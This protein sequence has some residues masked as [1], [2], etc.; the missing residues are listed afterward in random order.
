MRIAFGVLF[1][2]VLPLAAQEQDGPRLGFEGQTLEAD[3]SV[4]FGAPSGVLV[5]E[6]TAGGPAEAAGLKRDDVVVEIDGAP[7]HGVEELVNKAQALGIGGELKVAVLRGKERLP[8][9]WKLQA[10]SEFAKMVGV[11][12]PS[13]RADGWVGGEA[14]VMAKLAGSVVAIVIWQSV[15][16]KAAD[17]E[18]M[19][20]S[21]H[22]AY[23]AKGLV[24][25]PVHVIIARG[26]GQTQPAEE[27]VKYVEGKKFPMPVGHGSGER[28]YLGGQQI[29]GPLVVADY[30]LQVVPSVI[31]VDK[32][33]VVAARWEANEEIGT[34]DEAKKKIEELLAK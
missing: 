11:K 31:L 10:Y 12:A 3:E 22:E 7:L 30:R 19:F 27:G 2:L 9:S 29:A 8:M 15:D 32:A 24:V 20:L 4:T 14:P 16:P 28:F 17:T 34:G 5:N 13:I 1:V 26:P 6:V 18:K 23:G 21:W 33:G 25:V